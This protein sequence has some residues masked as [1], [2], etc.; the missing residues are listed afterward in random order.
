MALLVASVT[1]FAA[2]A[3][4]GLAVVVA[5]LLVTLAASGT[6]PL[7]VLAALRPALVLLAV[8]VLANGIVL[9]GEPGISVSGVARSATAVA[10]VVVVAGLAL[11]FSSTTTPPAIADAV[12]S[13]MAPLARL[14]VPVGAVSTAVSV[15][16]RFIPLASEEVERIRCAQMA[17]GARLDEGGA[18]RRLSAW[19]QVLVPLVVS[20]LRRADELAEAMEDRCYTGEQ[21]SM[22]QPLG[23]RDVA[24][25][26]GVAAWAA[27]ALVA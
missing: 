19:G 4:L 25:L 9:V 6:S 5:G 18:V 16:L 15:A 8:S 12:A 1:T 23:G 24:A 20:L 3:P 7:R 11:S 26:L 2:S 13:L 21:T 22:W 17:R 14:G 27:A 10:R